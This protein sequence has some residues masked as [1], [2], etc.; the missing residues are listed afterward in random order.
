MAHAEILGAH[1]GGDPAITTDS[2]L[3]KFGGCAAIILCIHSQADAIQPAMIHRLIS[4]LVY[5][6]PSSGSQGRIQIVQ[7]FSGRDQGATRSL[8]G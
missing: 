8:P 2:D 4:A 7:E 1:H 5:I 6:S 3:C